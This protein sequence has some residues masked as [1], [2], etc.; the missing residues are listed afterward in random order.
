MEEWKWIYFTD[1]DGVEHDYRGKYQVS[2]M[3]RVRSFADKQ[4]RISNEP[5]TY[6]NPKPQRNGYVCVHLRMNGESKFVK[7]HKLVAF[8]FLGY[9]HELVGE[10]V[11][12]NHINEI[13]HDNRIENL[14]WCT[15]KQNLNHGTIIER[16]S[17]TLTG[18][19]C[20]EDT[21]QKIAKA[22][23]KPV[24]VSHIETKQQVLF[25]SAKDVSLFLQVTI[26]VVRNRIRDGKPIQNYVLQYK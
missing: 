21:R 1:L 26:N 14:E 15:A 8:M 20:S 17:K 22:R 11:H 4:G 23:L 13:K 25:D 3:G 2:N 5:T 16:K 10:T 18:H 7:V 19:K 9:P 6:F 24:I 12:I